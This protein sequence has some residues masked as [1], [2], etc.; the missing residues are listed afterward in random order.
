[1]FTGIVEES[2][3]VREIRETTSGLSLT[4][5]TKKTHKESRLGSSICIDGVCLTVVGKRGKDLTF[6][7]SKSTLRLTT[8]GALRRGN[9][10]NLERPLKIGDRLGGHFVQGHVEGVGTILARRNEG[11]NVGYKIRCNP[12]VLSQLF[13][14]GS[15]A[16]DGISL[17]VT[18]LYRGAFEIYLI[19]HTLKVTGIAKKKVGDKVNLETDLLAKLSVSRHNRY[20]LSIDKLHK[21]R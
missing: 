6:D 10:V 9:F 17:T 5:R 7:V 8:L 21:N 12:S 1:M 3:T 20:I 13:P 19:P 4:V 18:H 15:V 14:R 11:K 16:V 2:G